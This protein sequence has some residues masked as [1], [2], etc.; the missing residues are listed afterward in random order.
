[1]TRGRDRRVGPDGQPARDQLELA[2][3]N[4]T[5][6]VDV[7]APVELD[8]HKGVPRGR[9]RPHLGDPRRAR[10]Q[11][12]ERQRDQPLDVL[13]GHAAV[14]GDDRDERGVQVRIDV[15]RHLRV[16]EHAEH[17]RQGDG[18][19]RQQP[20]GQREVDEAGDHHIPF[21][22]VDMSLQHGFQ[23]LRPQLESSAD[24]YLL[25]VRQPVEHFPQPVGLAAEPHGARDEPI[26]GR[27]QTP[28]SRPHRRARQPA[29]RPARDPLRPA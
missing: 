1:M 13:G 15:F 23:E 19:D 24:H 17:T 26:A 11:A 12:L 6:P 2:R 14:V 3:H 9:L 5:G 4:L 18:E 28:S 7:G 10:Q 27:P 25:A 8:G 29:A 21:G 16:D 22:S 20:P